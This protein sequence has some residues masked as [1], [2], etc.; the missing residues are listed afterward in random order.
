[1][2]KPL[3]VEQFR[4]TSGSLATLAPHLVLQ[5]F[6]TVY[7]SSVTTGEQVFVVEQ[8]TETYNFFVDIDYQVS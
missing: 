4:F 3:I 6:Y 7:V 1:M 5:D 8:K 2:A